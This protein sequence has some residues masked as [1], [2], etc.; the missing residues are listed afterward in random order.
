MYAKVET[1]RLTFIRLNQNK[2]PVDDC[3]HLRDAVACDGNS[4]NIGQLV[5]LPSSFTGG[6]CYMHERTQDAM[7]YF[8][9]YGRQDLFT[10]FTCNPLWPEI[11]D[12]LM[13]AQRSL[14]RH[15]IIARVFRQKVIKLMDLLTKGIAF[16][17]TLCHIYT[18]S[19]RNAVSHMLIY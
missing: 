17:K 12:S 3:I 4:H 6:S 15:D 2:L 5:I 18:S 13:V 10:T 14:D 16:G 19:A 8:R 9:N 1:E 7:T 11:T